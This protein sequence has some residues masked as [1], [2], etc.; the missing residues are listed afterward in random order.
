MMRLAGYLKNDMPFGATH[1]S[2][3]LSL[4]EAWD[5]AAFV[6]SQPRPLKMFKEDWVLSGKKPSDY[7]YGPY[8]DSFS[9]SQHKYG[10]YEPIEKAKKGTGR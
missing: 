1:Q 10:P 2:P 7:P 4:E 5:I 9:E 8:K 6:N 3:Q